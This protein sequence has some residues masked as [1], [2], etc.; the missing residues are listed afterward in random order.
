MK[1]N[2]DYNNVQCRLKSIEDEEPF[3][4]YTF[5]IHGNAY[6]GYG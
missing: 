6:D 2:L 1:H 4:Y 5:V 3:Y